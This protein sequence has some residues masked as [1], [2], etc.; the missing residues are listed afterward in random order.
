M[1]DF[2]LSTLL[3]TVTGIS[4]I[5]LLILL[6][7]G[8]VVLFTYLFRKRESPIT[9]RSQEDDID[10]HKAALLA[11]SLA[12][13]MESENKIHEFPLPPTA[14]VSAWQAV[15][16]SNIISKRGRIK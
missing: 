8:L 1:T 6:V 4:L 9:L 11:I 7:W 14:L 13:Q 3:I 12:I 10:K 5:L 15:M 2:S 16:R